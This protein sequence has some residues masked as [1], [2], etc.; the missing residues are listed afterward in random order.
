MNAFRR[1]TIRIFVAGLSIAYCAAQIDGDAAYRAFLKWRKTLENA[2]LGWD[3]ALNKY[4][5]QLRANGL[6]A[7]T[8]EKTLLVISAR[9]EAT[10]YDPIFAKPPKFD[11][12][13][14][15][16]LMEAVRDRTPGMALDVAMGQ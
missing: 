9:D 15:R 10:L 1:F 5:S 11:T 12:T 16:L 8:V 3:A 14:N 2:A 6:S 13:P 7:E 4:G